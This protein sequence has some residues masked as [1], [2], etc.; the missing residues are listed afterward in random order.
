MA[1][2][3]LDFVGGNDANDGTSFAN[4]KKTL[5][6][7]TGV[8]AGD[9]IRTMM[10][11]AASATG[12]DTVFTR[13]GIT[14]TLPSSGVTT[15][16]LYLDGAWTANTNV[17]CTTS[18]TR[19]Q[20]S[21]SASIT[22][23]N[24]FTTGVAAY[25]ATGTLNLST[26]QTIS[27]WVRPNAAIAAN[28]LRLDLCSDTI[29]AVPVNSFTVSK[30]LVANVWQCIT[31]DSGGAL[32][33][34]IASVS[35]NVL[36][37]VGNGPIILIDNVLAC[38]ALTDPQCLTLSHIISHNNDDFWSVRSINGTSIELDTQFNSGQGTGRG[39][40]AEW[41]NTGIYKLYTKFP[42]LLPS[43]QT[44]SG[45]QGTNSAWV[46]ISGGWDQVSMSTRIGDTWVDGILCGS[47]NVLFNTAGYVEITYFGCHRGQGT[48]PV[49]YN[50][51]SPVLPT[52][53][54]FCASAA[55]P[56]AAQI[57]PT[58]IINDFKT[59][60][61]GSVTLNAG[62]TGNSLSYNMQRVKLISQ[63]TTA[64]NGT[65]SPTL[66]TKSTVF[67]DIKVF[68]NTAQLFGGNCVPPNII[69][70]KLQLVSAGFFIPSNQ[71][72]NA[73]FLNVYDS[74]IYDTPTFNISTSA[75]SISSFNFFNLASSGSGTAGIGLTIT[76]NFY[77]KDC[78]FTDSTLLSI[79]PSGSIATA[80]F[81]HLNGSTT[82]NRTYYYGGYVQS[83]TTV[84][85]TGSGV[86]WMFKP[87]DVGACNSDFPISLLIGSIPCNA[88]Q[89][90][91]ASY[92]AARDSSNVNMRLRISGGQWAGVGSPGVDITTSMAPTPN[93]SPGSSDFV[94][95]SISATPTEN[96]VIQIFG[97]V[98]GGTTNAGYI[99][100]PVT[101]V[102]S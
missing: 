68:N 91:T 39:W 14:L 15:Q 71:V 30:A 79:S 44:Y 9:T 10:S 43:T 86:A 17:T 66:A 64:I 55:N 12:W 63:S 83:Q 61:S 97:D 93:A 75:A 62:N 70:L 34:S 56:A 87:T 59:C 20:G 72:N 26:Y 40:F 88:G 102:Y 3:Y 8:N 27:F 42:I 11:N 69:R 81:E 65:L 74:E 35:L 73:R 19:Q 57:G 85:K 32:G 22:V 67:N 28:S 23:G 82:D 80:K 16:A 96:C 18:I 92:W 29:G 51:L 58:G 84:T 25:Y 99:D 38:K 45:A 50:W 89:T 98:W 24:A 47:N 37:D 95:Y 2:W 90:F 49:S 48:G 5:D 1:D 60:G 31:L 94:E 52:K 33:S 6:S 77:F 46:T 76:S 21:N 36:I 4:R 7:L 41:E 101:V 78:N 53:I 13:Q 100:G 54:S